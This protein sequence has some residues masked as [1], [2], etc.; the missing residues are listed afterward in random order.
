MTFAI[1]QMRINSEDSWVKV[2]YSIAMILF[3]LF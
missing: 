3:T 1:T 2:K